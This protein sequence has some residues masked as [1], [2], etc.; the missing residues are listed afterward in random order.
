MNTPRRR[1][2]TRITL[3][4]GRRLLVYRHRDG[5]LALEDADTRDRTFISR[6]TLRQVAE[7]REA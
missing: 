6:E 3:P 7:E 4:A 5:R 2:V 1:L